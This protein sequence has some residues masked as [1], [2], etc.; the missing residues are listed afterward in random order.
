MS[1]S[2]YKKPR[3][4]ETAGP[5][6]SDAANGT[7]NLPRDRKTLSLLLDKVSGALEFLGSS[8]HQQQ[9]WLRILCNTAKDRYSILAQREFLDS[10]KSAAIKRF[11]I[12]GP[13]L[14]PLDKYLDQKKLTSAVA[15]LETAKA[16]L[17]PSTPKTLDTA[18]LQRCADA[19]Q[20]FFTAEA[21]VIEVFRAFQLKVI[22]AL[23][24]CADKTDNDTDKFG[25]DLVSLP[26]NLD[27]ARLAKLIRD[28]RR[29]ERSK[30]AIA[31]QFT[32]GNKKRARSLLRQ[33]R[34]YPV[35][36]KRSPT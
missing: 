25:A 3:R 35:L 18:E 1:R 24:K 30:M 13:S 9:H 2:K 28:N 14:S 23:E 26:K 29:V 12:G 34:R 17:S 10:L 31:L 15:K 16:G 11:A 4:I 20:R 21:D 7:E 32:E 27:V 36:L 33:L 19:F 8:H 5:H 6:R 22:A